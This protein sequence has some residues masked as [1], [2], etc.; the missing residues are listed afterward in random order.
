MHLFQAKK[1]RAFA[2]NKADSI[3]K[4]AESANRKLTET[5]EQEFNTAMAA[6]ESLRQ[7]IAKMER[8][9]TLRHHMVNGM[10]L[11][12]NPS[13]GR[14]MP[15]QA[16][17]QSRTPMTPVVLSEDYF[18]AFF[19]WLG[20]GGHNT[21]SAALYEG[22][23]SAGGF[24]VPVNVEGNVVPLAP[25]DMGVRE[26]ATVLPT[27]MD[28]KV[29]R[30]TTISTA[31]AKAEGDGT[32]T[33]LFTESEPVLDQFTL[34]AFLAGVEHQA[35]WE[36]LQDVPAFQQFAVGDMLLA[37]TIYEENLFVNGSGS[38]QAQGLIGNVGAG[39]TCA[40]HAFS[41]ILDST[42]D[43]MGQLKTAYHNNASWLMSRATS[44][45]LRKA[46]KQAN[47]YE[48]VFVRE[49]GKDY[50]HGYP[51]TYSTAMPAVA[52]AVTP[53]LF[54]DFKQGYVIG[55]R[56]GSG[57]NVKILDQIKA[58]EGLVVFLAY[59]RVDG[60][61]RRSEAIQALQTT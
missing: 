46:Q 44:I 5:E 22:S 12:P 39:V 45:G 23:N 13:G 49:G 11:P 34:S 14:V 38:G 16:L 27:S 9:S 21:A 57:I 37:Q 10:L 40:T 2:L 19:E 25:T 53:I 43:V 47:L 56:G 33:H 15:S 52:A 35:S 58:T 6:A 17:G 50:L 24:A 20:S 41:D 61:V 1:D 31:S 42:F 48:P 8:H 4:A 3:V 30:A 55:D 60:R 26:I 29:P 51:V 28:I 18:N 54:G 32:G 59:R 36:L 7:Q